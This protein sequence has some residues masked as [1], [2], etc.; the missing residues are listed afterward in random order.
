MAKTAIYTAIFGTYDDLREQL[1]LTDVDYLCFT[2]SRDLQAAPPWQVVRINGLVAPGDAC[3]HPRMRAKRFKCFPHHYLHTYD[4]T[5]WVDG[6]IDVVD[7]A[8]AEVVTGSIN[9]SGM[10]VFAHPDRNCIYEEAAE[11]V[12][13]PKYDRAALIKQ[14]RHYRSVGYPAQNGLYAGGVIGR[15]TNSDLTEH[16]CEDWWQEITRWSYQDQLSL[17]VVCWCAGITLGLIPGDLWTS[18]LIRHNPH[19]SR[20]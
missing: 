11:S 15:A 3:L 19:H 13:M 1:V 12:R 10:A 16:I 9:D 2:D 20:L 17:P 6:A 4:H 7:P 14:I 18:P 8:F 5:I